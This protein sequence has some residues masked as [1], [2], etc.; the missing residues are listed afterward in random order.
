V[1]AQNTRRVLGAALAGQH[2]GPQPGGHGQQPGGLDPSVHACRN[3]PGLL[4][5]GELGGDHVF[6]PSEACNRVLIAYAGSV[7]DSAA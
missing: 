5:P 6:N 1:V 3:L 2:A 7:R 4:G